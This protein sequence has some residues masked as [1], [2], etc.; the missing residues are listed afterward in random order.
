MSAFTPAQ[1][2]LLRLF[3]RQLPETDLVEI[4]NLVVDYLSKKAVSAADKAFDE[5][6]Y[7]ASDVE[8]WK[9]G[10]FRIKGK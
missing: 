3:G 2:D 7:T 10:H 6:G 1:L 5:K 4:R 9:T 8:S